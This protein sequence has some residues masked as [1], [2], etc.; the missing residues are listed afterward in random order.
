MGNYKDPEYKKKYYEK[1][2]EKLIAGQARYN[3][4]NMVGILFRSAKHRAKVLNLSFNIEKS[5]IQIPKICPFFLLPLTSTQGSGRCQM[6]ASLDRI[7]SSKGYIKGNIQVLSSLANKM[8]QN[9]TQEQL[10]SFA[11]G[12]LN[13]YGESLNG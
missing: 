4:K 1:N 11:K 2:K 9:A 3:E 13:F 7:D 5:D 12:V 8:K 10:I 6:N